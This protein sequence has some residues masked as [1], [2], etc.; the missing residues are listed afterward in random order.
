[1]FEKII[2]M[3][4]Q[5][6][7]VSQANLDENMILVNKNGFDLI[8][9]KNNQDNHG[10]FLVNSVQGHD[11]YSYNSES[12]H[13]YHVLDGSGEFVVDGE[14]LLV[15]T[16][17]TITIKPNQVFYYKGKMLMVFEMLP[18]FKEENNHVVKEVNYFETSI[19]SS[20]K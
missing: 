3:Y 2:K 5:G 20:K 16:G 18:N 1:M 14:T 9:P 15:K 19:W 13:I 7:E 8:I 4:K 11:C 6:Q 10:Y 17:D 12:T